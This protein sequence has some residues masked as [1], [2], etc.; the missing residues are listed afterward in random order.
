MIRDDL[1]QLGLSDEEVKIYLALLELGGGYVSTV[2][3]KAK[4]H[5]VTSYNTL[6]NLVKRRLVSYA[7]HKHIRFYSP[8]PPQVLENQFE[9]KYETAKKI[10]PELLA[11]QRS[12]SFTPKIRYFE[13]KENMVT[14]FDDMAHTTT[15]ILGYTNLLPLHELFPDVII[16]FG[17]TIEERNIKVRLLSPKDIENEHC[18]EEFFKEPVQTGLMEILC[19]NPHQYPFK[20]GIFFYDDKMA[21]ISY[22][23][24]ELLGVIIQSAVNT[25][26]QKAMFDLAWLGATSFIVR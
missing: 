1:L 6:G 10:L 22:A 15:E 16:R 5:R 19:V 12:A 26:T 18:I 20:N 25:Q 2:A 3:R 23:K 17:K 21:I 14:I 24:Q 9:E 4:V 11:L 13:E 8:E 7:T